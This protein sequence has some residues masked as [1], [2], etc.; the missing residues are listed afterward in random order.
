[1]VTQSQKLLCTQRS[2]NHL[3][4]F[5]VLKLKSF[6]TLGPSGVHFRRCLNRTNY[7]EDDGD[8]DDESSDT[9]EGMFPFQCK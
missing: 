7:N 5:S 2:P 9:H 1:M 8:Y 6:F 4:K 3:I